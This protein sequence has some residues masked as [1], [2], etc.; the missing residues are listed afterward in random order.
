MEN[1]FEQTLIGRYAAVKEQAFF[2]RYAGCL[3][4]RAVKLNA[5]WLKTAKH[6]I[7]VP[8]DI[9]TAGSRLAFE[10]NSMDALLMPHAHEYGGSAVLWLAEAYRVLKPEG[11]LLLTG[12][13]PHSLWRFSNWFDGKMLPLRQNCLALNEIKRQTEV[14]GF[15]TAF[16]K[17]MA[18]I[19]PV[20]TQKSLD[21]W[22]FLE[23]AGDRWWPQC[24]AVYGLV[25]IK[26]LT[27]VHPLPEW[28]VQ[29]EEPVA[30]L[31]LAKIKG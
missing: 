20:D 26:R 19:P 8:D 15:E 25:L 6:V 29:S 30:A 21:F 2:D 31:G 10:A 27:G 11:M 7:C 14:L 12:F 23:K 4:E 16:G 22:Q 28:A 1:W 3:Q 17:F 18:Y 9:L 13:N 24:A 5:P